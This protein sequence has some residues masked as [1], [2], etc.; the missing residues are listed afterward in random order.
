MELNELNSFSEF[1]NEKKVQVKRKYKEYPEKIV[2][3]KTPVRNKIL[4]FIASKGKVS[5]EEITE[6]IQKFNEENERTTKISWLRKNKNFVKK[7]TEKDG[8]VNYTLTKFGQ[9]LVNKLELFENFS[10]ED[11]QIIVNYLTRN[12]DAIIPKE[13]TLKIAKILNIDLDKKQQEKTKEQTIEE[14]LNLVFDFIFEEDDASSLE[15]TPGQG[16]VKA[17]TKDETGSG[18]TFENLKLTSKQQD[19]AKILKDRYDEISKKDAIKFIKKEYGNYFDLKDIV[20]AYKAV[21][22]DVSSLENTPGQ[23]N[24]KAPTKNETGSG[25]TFSAKYKK[26]EN[27]LEDLKPG[28]RVLYIKDRKLTPAEILKKHT[29]GNNW[30]WIKDNKGNEELLKAGNKAK[31]NKQFELVNH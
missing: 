8:T 1:L 21:Y 12:A 29:K 10:P 20:Y 26:N 6:F 13:E 24:V 3:F 16:N 5:K 17:L 19:I 23:G 30:Y 27:D 2:N 25:D 22:E 31:P 9:K 18:D 15:N 28:T 7:I 14:S 11:K 4:E